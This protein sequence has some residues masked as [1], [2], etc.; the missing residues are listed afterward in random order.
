MALNNSR[1]SNVAEPPDACVSWPGSFFANAIS[2][3]TDFAGTSMLIIKT[4]GLAVTRPSGT[5]S[6]CG[7]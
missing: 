2:S 7:S 1:E 6:F 3:A 4:S 5:K